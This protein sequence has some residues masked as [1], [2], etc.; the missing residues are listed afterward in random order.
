MVEKDLIATWKKNYTQSYN[1]DSSEEATS[2]R[3]C[4]IISPDSTTRAAMKPL[5]IADF[6]GIFCLLPIGYLL[7]FFAF[8][9]ERRSKKSRNRQ[10]EPVFLGRRVA[11]VR[12][13]NL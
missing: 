6:G 1:Q 12:L 2:K 4:E 11:S 5:S 8:T 9:I 7:S 10:T 13:E 3:K